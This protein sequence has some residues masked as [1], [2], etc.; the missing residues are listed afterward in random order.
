M[1]KLNCGYILYLKYK[2]HINRIASD[3][4]TMIIE[5]DPI[6]VKKGSNTVPPSFLFRGILFNRTITL[7]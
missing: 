2:L 4:K 6:R 5:Y 3:T 7:R 1:I